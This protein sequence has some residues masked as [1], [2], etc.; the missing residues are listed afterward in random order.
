MNRYLA[1]MLCL[2]LVCCL[3]PAA[4]TASDAEKTLYIPRVEGLAEDFIMGMD[5]SSVLALERSGV[6]F[7]DASGQEKD[8]FVILKEN[9]IDCIRVR[10]WNDPYDSSGRSYGGGGCDLAN[11]VEIGRRAAAAGQTLLVDFHYSD[12]WADPSK[13]Q[14]PK[15]WRGM[16]VED[17]AEAM[18]RYTLESLNAIRDG[19][20]RVAMVQIGN[21]TNGM[22]CGEKTW[23][24]IV[25]QLMARA[26]AAIREFDPAVRI[27]VHFANPENTDAYL[28]WAGKLAYYSLDYDVFATSYYPYW[29]GTLDNLK[30]VL[31]AIRETYG[32]DVMV[33]ETSYAYTLEDTDFSGNT[34]GEGGAYEAPWPFTVQGQAT[35]VREVI[36]AVSSVG[37]IGVFYWEGAWITVGGE[38]WEENHVLWETYGSGWASSFAR[39]YDPAD[40]GR[41]YGGSACDN[42]AMFDATGKAL[43][44]LAVFGLVRE[45][46]LAEVVPEAVQ[47]VEMTVDVGSAIRLPETVWAV[48]NDMSRREVSAEWDLSALPASTDREGDYAVTGTAGGMKCTARIH[49]RLNNYARNPSFEE[50]DLSM[51]RVKDLAGCDQLYAEDKRVDSLTGTKHWHFYSAKAQSVYFTLEQTLEGLPEGTWRFRISVMGGDAGSQEVYSYV[52]IDGET[53]ATAPAKITSYNNWDT[54]EIV[55]TCAEGQEVIAGISVRCDGAGAW[56]K[57]DDMTVNRLI[58]E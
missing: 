55:F 54:P 17:K 1:V 48:M 8:L 4:G 58:G 3:A 41:F 27:C 34:I 31:S 18:Y 50:E 32:K 29:H 28:N 20:G 26:A 25:W 23:K 44:S 2:M 15:A 10:V 56:G 52:K 37:G 24:K 46:Q 51:W 7:R 39:E 21:E 47:D 5:V 11:A 22:F 57:I 36:D 33:A 40:A 19:G 42:Q 12:F 35:E 14:A 9:G 49:V 43:A 53:V 45:G 30:Y 38:S 16:T 13:Q 6:T